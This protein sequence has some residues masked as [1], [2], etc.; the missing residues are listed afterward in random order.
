[1]STS[2]QRT[3]RNLRVGIAGTVVLLLVAVTI[4]AGGVG[5]LPSISAYYYTGARNV[6]VGALVAA[7]V[8]IVVLS[9]RGLQRA[10]LSAAGLFAPL[11]ALVPTPVRAGTVP[12][13]DDGCG[14]GTTCVPSAVIPDIEVGIATYL[15]VGALTVAVGVVITL[16]GDTGSAARNLPSLVIA[17]VV[18]LVVF[19]AWLSAR[20]AFVMGAHLVAAVVFFG[21][22]ALAAVVNAFTRAG[23]QPAW[24]T[25]LYWIVAV[26]MTVDIAV[27]VVVASTGGIADAAVPPLLVGEVVALMLFVVF[28]VLQSIEKWDD[29]DPSVA[30]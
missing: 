21:L 9:G 23:A 27:I 29:A 6:F 3:Y 14:A 12:G 18:L 11:I 25:S 28:W 30:A 20:T 19:G 10:L 17:S 16:L 26:A 13:Y 22:F 4:V 15:A 8:A 24:R 5:V 1:M 7:A 2:L